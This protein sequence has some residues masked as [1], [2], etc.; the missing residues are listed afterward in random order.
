MAAIALCGA[1]ILTL[2]MCAVLLYAVISIAHDNEE[3]D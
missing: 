3:D 2:A 1:L